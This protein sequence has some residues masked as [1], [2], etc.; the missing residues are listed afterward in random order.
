[1]FLTQLDLLKSISLALPL[2]VRKLLVWKDE[3]GRAIVRRTPGK[4]LSHKSMF[5]CDCPK[6]LARGSVDQGSK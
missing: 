1:M 2:D 4:F 6:R 5:L 3:D